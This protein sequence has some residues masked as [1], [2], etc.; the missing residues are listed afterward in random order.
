MKL[1]AYPTFPNAPI[2]EAILDITVELPEY[3]DLKKLEEFHKHAIKQRFPEKQVRQVLKATFQFPKEK[4]PPTSIPTAGGPVGYLFR[5][6]SENKVV[7]ARLDG[8]SFNKLKPYESWKKFRDEGRELWELYLDVAKP[9]RIR[10]ISL[11]YI[12][13]IE[14][15]LPFKDFNEY[16]L[17]N[18]QVAPE[19]PQALSNFFMHIQIPFE[20]QQAIAT[21]IQTMEKPT[22]SQKLPL[23]MDIDVVQHANFI[24]DS[25]ENIWDEFEKLRNI[26]N[27]I[28]FNSI[29]D[30]AKELFR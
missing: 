13:R 19:L 21:I 30:K 12:N 9:I 26:K 11:R 18:P 24:A 4:D 7:Q 14:A 20:E 8:F 3:I 28:F 23:I 1:N 22:E 25:F 5:S 17:T 10:R 6:S 2:T 15:P 27:D 16:I 29:T